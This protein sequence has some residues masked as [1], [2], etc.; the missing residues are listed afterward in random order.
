MIHTYVSATQLKTSN[1]CHI[2]ETKP[3]VLF[4][5]LRSAVCPQVTTVLTLAFLIPKHPH[6]SVHSHMPKSHVVSFRP[7]LMLN[8]GLQAVCIVCSLLLPLNT[9]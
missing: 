4:P 9:I 6:N 7:F 1:N 2:V 3:R 5:Q 8:K